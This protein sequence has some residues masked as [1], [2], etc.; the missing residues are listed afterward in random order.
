MNKE[1]IYQTYGETAK[2]ILIEAYPQ[3]VASV[4]LWIEFQKVSRKASLSLVSAVIGGLR[5][6][7]LTVENKHG[8]GY[9][10]NPPD[11]AST[12]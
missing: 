9:R 5:D 2:N 10:L 7:G 12:E 11:V 1:V 3:Y 6:H 4:T 8:V